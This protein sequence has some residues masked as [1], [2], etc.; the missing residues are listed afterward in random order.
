LEKRG[1]GILAMDVYGQLQGI[2]TFLARRVRRVYQAALGSATC[3]HGRGAWMRRA[4]LMTTISGTNA[5]EL[6]ADSQ[7]HCT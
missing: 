6:N 3:N 1:A 7:M 5:R 2:R 4:R